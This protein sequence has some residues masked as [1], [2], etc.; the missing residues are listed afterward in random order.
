M[1]I[2]IIFNILEREQK[3]SLFLIWH[4]F[5]VQKIEKFKINQRRWNQGKR[6]QKGI[7]G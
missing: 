7:E 3:I 2:F 5:C 1:A 4:I 6:I